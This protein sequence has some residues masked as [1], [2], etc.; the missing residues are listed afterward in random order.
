MLLN[1]I[2]KPNEPPV[3]SEV[4]TPKMTIPKV[5]YIAYLQDTE[6]NIFGIFQEDPSAH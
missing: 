3:F 4:I 5:G 1:S 6:G 2:L